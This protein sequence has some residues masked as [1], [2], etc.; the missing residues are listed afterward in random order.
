LWP[1]VGSGGTSVGGS[2]LLGRDLER[3]RDALRLTIAAG[4]AQRFWSIDFGVAGFVAVLVRDEEDALPICDTLDLG[5]WGRR[6]EVGWRSWLEALGVSGVTVLLE[7]DVLDERGRE[8]KRE[9]GFVPDMELVGDF[10]MLERL[11]DF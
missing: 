7:L 2:G 11:L 9:T 6:E 3:E 5:V 1:A 4:I 8:G 10:L